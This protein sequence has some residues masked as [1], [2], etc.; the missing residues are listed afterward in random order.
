MQPLRIRVADATH[1]P[2]TF[3]SDLRSALAEELKLDSDE[4]ALR[5]EETPRVPGA[6]WALYEIYL[7][8]HEIGEMIALLAR[9][10]APKLAHLAPRRR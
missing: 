4:L 7:H 1:L 2:Q 3:E 6:D 5:L 8:G 10:L 9:E